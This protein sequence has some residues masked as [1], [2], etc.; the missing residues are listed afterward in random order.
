M[1]AVATDGSNFSVDLGEGEAI[2]CDV[3]NN[4]EN[5]SGLTPTPAPAVTVDVTLPNTGRGVHSESRSPL[6]VGFALIAVIVGGL[7]V[8]AS[9][10]TV[11]NAGN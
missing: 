3:Y 11:R 7:S 8:V 1:F 2:V 6:P 10:R 5:L 9:R 4:P